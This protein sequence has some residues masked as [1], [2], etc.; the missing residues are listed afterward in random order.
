VYNVSFNYVYGRNALNH[1]K[2]DFYERL[3]FS[4]DNHSEIIFPEAVEEVKKKIDGMQE[5]TSASY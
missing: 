5:V 1:F 3:I 2:K 4:E